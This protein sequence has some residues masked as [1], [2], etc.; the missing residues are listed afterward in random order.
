MTRPAQRDLFVPTPEA[1]PEPFDFLAHDDPAT[2]PGS[3]DDVPAWL[4][5]PGEEGHIELDAN[6]RPAVG[7]K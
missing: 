1:P 2:R 5:V 4:R 3:L 7:G 6:M